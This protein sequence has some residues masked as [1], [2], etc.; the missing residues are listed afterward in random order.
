MVCPTQLLYGVLASVKRA[1]YDF[2]FIEQIS[3]D[4]H[5]LS[6]LNSKYEDF[7]LKFVLDSI[8][9]LVNGIE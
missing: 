5:L 9:F 2:D 1:A 7:L 4:H 3:S 6:R 8:L